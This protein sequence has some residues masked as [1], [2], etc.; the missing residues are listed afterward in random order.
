VPL[1]RAVAAGA[2]AWI[3]KHARERPTVAAPAA[4]SKP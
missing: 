2:L 1:P 4:L 3:G